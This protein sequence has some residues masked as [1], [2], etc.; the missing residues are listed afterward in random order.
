M[1]MFAGISEIERVPETMRN[2]HILTGLSAREILIE[3]CHR[4]IF[5]TDM[6][7]KITSCRTAHKFI[8]VWLAEI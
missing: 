3:F 4:Q 7:L 6:A 8:Q 2:L 5:K 1:G